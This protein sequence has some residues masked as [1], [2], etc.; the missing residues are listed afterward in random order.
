MLLTR[1]SLSSA[2]VLSTFLVVAA[3]GGSEGEEAKTTSRPSDTPATGTRDVEPSTDERSPAST[4]EQSGRLGAALDHPERYY[5]LYANPE[6]PDRQWFVTEAKRPPE[7]E[8]APEI[9]PGH[10]A[11]G[12]MFGDV[13]P[14]IMKTLSTTEFEQVWAMGAEPIVVIFEL[15]TDGTAVAMNFT[16]EGYASMGRLERQG[17]LPAEWQ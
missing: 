9:P 4:P 5:G 6:T 8:Q 17:D 12:A 16:D 10:L 3:C 13:S 14:W 1:S 2:V 7:A 15:G 11:I